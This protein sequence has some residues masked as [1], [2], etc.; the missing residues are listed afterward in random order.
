MVRIIHARTEL[1]EHGCTHGK[2]PSGRHISHAGTLEFSSSTLEIAARCVIT[3]LR[4][5]LDRYERMR[6]DGLAV[7]WTSFG[8]PHL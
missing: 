6:R 7:E 2:R 8:S 1:D 4:E 3:A 5:T